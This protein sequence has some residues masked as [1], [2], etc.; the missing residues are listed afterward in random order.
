MSEVNINGSILTFDCNGNKVSI[1]ITKADEETSCELSVLGK[2]EYFGD[3]TA[4]KKRLSSLGIP[5]NQQ[6]DVLRVWNK[7]FKPVES[8]QQTNPQQQSINNSPPNNLS[9]QQTGEQKSPI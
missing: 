8:S 6:L 4:L 1:K 2:T 5:A 9:T 7:Y 3:F